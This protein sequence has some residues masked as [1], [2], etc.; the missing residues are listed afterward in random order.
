[1]LPF[2]SRLGF[3]SMECGTITPK[4]QVGN[5]R[6]RVFRYP[7]EASLRNAMGFPN[8]GMEAC[9]H[10]LKN[11]PAN[12]AVGVNIGKSKLASPTE[13]LD[14]YAALYER[15][16]P[17]ADWVVVNISSPNTPGLRDLQQES[18]LKD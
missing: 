2:F 12:F 3:G 4:P 13:A 5:P 11:R 18:W 16:A 14:E 15:L 1:A 17:L 9:A 8:G 10:E 6:P 7:A